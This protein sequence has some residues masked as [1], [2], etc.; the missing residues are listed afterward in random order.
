MEKRVKYGVILLCLIIL[1]VTL[2]GYFY[3]V[4]DKSPLL[5]VRSSITVNA[6]DLIG[7]SDTDEALFNHNYLY[8]VLSVRGV[9]RK[10]RKNKSGVTVLLGGH[11]ALPES[12]SCSLDSL[13]N[14]HHDLQAGDSC[15]IQG[16]CA[17]RLKDIILLQCIIEK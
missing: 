3:G 1:G 10:V 8:K 12:V 5:A 11:P 4:S 14:L 2:Y 17:G 13:Y 6:A 15:T 16:S 9:I 7:L